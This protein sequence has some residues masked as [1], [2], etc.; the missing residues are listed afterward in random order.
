MRLLSAAAA[1]LVLC[2][3]A[4]LGINSAKAGHHLCAAAYGKAN[5]CQARWDNRFKTCTC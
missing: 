2:M 4:P 1:C 3:V 5:H